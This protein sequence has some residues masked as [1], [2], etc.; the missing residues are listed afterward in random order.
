M[1]RYVRLSV[2]V[3]G[4]TLALSVAAVA[5][6]A[7]APQWKPFGDAAWRPHSGFNSQHG[8]VTSSDASGTFGGIELRNGPTDPNA[9]DAL[10][11]DFNAD[12]TGP[13]G[14]SPRLV[15]IF[16]DTNTNGYGVLRPLNWTADTWTHLDGLTGNNWDNQNG[17]SSGVCGFFVFGTTWTAVKAC[18]PGA[19]ITSMFLVNDSG[20]LYPSSGE[21]VVLDNVTVNDAVA[22]GPGN[23]E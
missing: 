12:Q 20:W 19:D 13:S 17:T 11:F 14:G 4:A 15:V 5:L 8:L 2:A 7:P 10:S 16:S 21:T 3:L 23:S 9:I 18:H 22:A 6:A 1:H